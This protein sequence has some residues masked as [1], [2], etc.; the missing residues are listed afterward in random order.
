[1]RSFGSHLLAILFVLSLPGGWMQTAHGVEPG[2]IWSDEFDGDGLPDPGKWVYETGGD[3]WGNQEA[4]YFTYM[5]PE[6]ARVENGHLVIEAHKEHWLADPLFQKYNDYTSARL[7]SKGS[8]DWLYGRIEVRAKLPSGPGTWTSI[9]ML[10]TESVYGPWPRS[11]QIGIMMYAGNGANWVN[12]HA[13][14]LEANPMTGSALGDW[15]FVGDAETEFHVY[16]ID[17]APDRI[18][19]QIDGEEYFFITNPGT[20]WADWPFDQPFH[21]VLNFS[22]GGTIGGSIDPSIWPQALEIDYVRVYDQGHTVSLDTDGDQIPN[23]LDPDDD[24]DGLSDVDEHYRG[25]NLLHPDSDADGFSDFEE[26]VA[27]SNPLR[28]GSVPGSRNILGNPGFA[29]EQFAPWGANTTLLGQDGQYLSNFGTWNFAYAMTDVLPEYGSGGSLFMPFL[30]NGRA[31]G[32]EHVLSQGF[33][34]DE[35][36]L[37][38]GD[39][40]TFR[41][42]ASA[43]KEVPEILTEAVIFIIDRNWGRLPQSVAIPIGPDTEEFEVRAILETGDVMLVDIGFRILTFSGPESWIRFSNLEATLNEPTSWGPWEIHSGYVDS[44]PWMGW[45][46]VKNDPWVWS[47]DL[48]KWLY[49]P[50]QGVTESGGWVYV[51]K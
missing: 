44:S 18:S 42:K 49:C 13:S 3:G 6:N 16:A 32:I 1:M 34:V 23:S 24:N 51:P 12:G 9:H 19:W 21:L 50:G 36:D 8:G 46:W 20:G 45:L 37:A 22:V 30:Y 26:V 33:F 39:L 14:S 7:L 48:S 40:L 5:R 31:A 29:G 28:S 17:W 15:I 47:V 41:G 38:P 11:G 35:L 4:Q 2:L 27:G 10:P 43:G 25:S